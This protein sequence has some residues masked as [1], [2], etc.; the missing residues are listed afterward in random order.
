MKT[1]SIYGIPFTIQVK[2]TVHEVGHDIDEEMPLMGEICFMS[3]SINIIDSN[4]PRMLRVLL[5]EI[6]HGIVEEG[7]IARMFGKDGRHDEDAV[8]QLAVGLA[9]A[10]ESLGVTE[11]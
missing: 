3:H 9:I 10:L 1:V 8:D 7:H 4:K 2:S 5:H 11:L 6:I